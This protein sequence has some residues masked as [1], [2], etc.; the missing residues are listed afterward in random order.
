MKEGWWQDGGGTLGEQAAS[1]T[2]LMK[3][4][5]RKQYL[6]KL[7]SFSS[8]RDLG[9]INSFIANTATKFLITRVL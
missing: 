3:M 9:T 1:I 4:R 7:H 8:Y 5:T 6:E 2:H